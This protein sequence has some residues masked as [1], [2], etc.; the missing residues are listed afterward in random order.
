MN[1][2][3]TSALPSHIAIIMDGNGRWANNRGLPRAAGHRAGVKTLRSIVERCVA[4]NI[5]V[6]T[7]YA[8]SS[9]NWGRPGQEV[10]FLLDLFMTALNEEVDALHEN[11][12]RLKFI[13]ERSAF[14]D[15][16]QE[17]IAT[18]EKL[19][20]G[21][22]GLNLNIAA[23]YGGRWDIIEVA[24]KLALQV[25]NQDLKADD[26]NENLFS[27]KLSLADLPEPDLF[28]RTGGEQRVSNYLLWQ[29]AYT[30]LY[31]TDLLWPEF[32]QKALDD[33]INWFEGRQRRFGKTSEQIQKANQV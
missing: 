26:I 13:G 20:E 17:T 14:P 1:S 22:K 7:V 6:L 25:A 27:Q 9:E 21:N 11:D 23:N 4:R 30:E 28:I 3:K 10:S 2:N 5:H 29:I 18:A 33:A 12:V 8:F 16:L 19:T 31:F 15:K 24:R 32:S